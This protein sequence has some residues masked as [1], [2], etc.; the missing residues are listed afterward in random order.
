MGFIAKDSGGGDF[1]PVPAGT[2][3]AVCVQ[4]IDLGTQYSEH[5]KN[6][7]HKVLLGWELCGDERQDS[8]EPF[9]IWHRYTMS[10]HENAVL[11]AHLEAWR[12]KSF[13]ESELAGFDVSRILGKPCFVN[14]SHNSNNGKTYANVAAVM[15][16]TKGTP[17]PQA[18]ANRVVFDIENPDM[19]VFESFSDNLKATIKSSPEWQAREGGGD[20]SAASAGLTPE[21]TAP[22]TEDEIP[23]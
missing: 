22:M 17:V 13:D 19:N 11:R 14:V 6:S 3:P 2:Y 5:Y 16:M 1:T 20:G 9:L 15:A 21:Q 8:G 7:K 12:G 10:L 23:F 18:S 4:V